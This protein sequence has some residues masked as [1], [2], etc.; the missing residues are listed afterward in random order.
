MSQKHSYTTADALPFDTATNLVRR[1]YRDEDY[2]M[3]LLIGCG[4]FFGLRISDLLSLTWSQILNVEEFVIYEKKTGKRRVIR[5][6]RGFQ[7]HIQDCHRALNIKD[8]SQPCFLNRYGS[9]ISIQ[10]INRNFKAMRV[11]Y[12]LKINNF[13]T[14]TCRKTWALKV[15]Q[16]ENAEGRGEMALVL[17]S[18]CLN[19]SSVAITR[20]YLGLKQEQIAGVYDS[21]QF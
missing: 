9:V 2:R 18:E 10:M 16:N 5:V 8:D 4:I 17:L 20:R 12:N 1:L 15:Y 21:L 19:H 11:K 14:H 7:G 13:S 3:S 6:N